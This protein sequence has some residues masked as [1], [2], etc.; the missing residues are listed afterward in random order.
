MRRTGPPARRARLTVDVERYLADRSRVWGSTLRRRTPRQVAVDS[1]LVAV[2]ER[3][4]TRDGHCCQVGL[5]CRAAGRCG[6]GLEL[7]HTIP[8]GRDVTRVLDDDNCLSVCS[9]HH[10]RIHAH[11]GWATAVGLMGSTGDVV[12]RGWV[13]ARGVQAS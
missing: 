8:R 7:S 10:R 13:V 12:V 3:V 6:G 5:R 4:F 2:R 11:P 1:D 9:G